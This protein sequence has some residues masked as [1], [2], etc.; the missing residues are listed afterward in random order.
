M[1]TDGLGVVGPGVVG[2]VGPPVGGAAEGEG[3]ADGVAAGTGVGGPA[4]EEG[5]AD[6]V[7][8]GTGSSSNGSSSNGS[9]LVGESSRAAWISSGLRPENRFLLGG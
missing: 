4:G 5:A 9:P 1:M 6:V 8:A 2:V 3:A 7:A